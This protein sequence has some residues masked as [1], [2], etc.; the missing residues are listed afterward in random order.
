[1]MIRTV[2]VL[3]A[4]L[5]VASAAPAAPARYVIVDRST[6]TLMS[7]ATANAMWNELLTPTLVKLYPP[8]KWG[9]ASE[10]EGGFNAAKTCVITARA[11]LMPR[12]GK[13]L[14]FTPAKTATAFDALPSAT[15]AQCKELARLKLKE[16]MQGVVA[17][18]S[19]R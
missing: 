18:L 2:A 4:L 7:A 19:A 3:I 1:M 13:A 5:L 10:V 15:E 16:A 17:S 14:L 9:F 11:M 8:G 12:R 6:E